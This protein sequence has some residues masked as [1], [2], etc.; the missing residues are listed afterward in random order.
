M[1]PTANAEAN[2]DVRH[3]NMKKLKVLICACSIVLASCSK[4]DSAESDG[5]FTEKQPE[6][7]AMK[8]KD[9]S[10]TPKKEWTGESSYCNCL[11]VAMSRMQISKI[12]LS[13]KQPLPD[14]EELTVNRPDSNEWI[15][16]QEL[17]Y[18]ELDKLTIIRILAES[19]GISE[20]TGS[21]NG[22]ID[23]HDVVGDDGDVVRRAFDM[24]LNLDGDEPE[25]VIT[26][27]GVK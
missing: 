12:T 2:I 7:V 4:R 22:S 19:A 15:R 5:Q 11:L 3:Q 1:L 20:K 14:L 16:A 25:L 18:A 10:I 26:Q 9:A 27:H 6:A 17:Q 8:E 21:R 24:V 13:T 23:V